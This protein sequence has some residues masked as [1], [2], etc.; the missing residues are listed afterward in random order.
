MRAV[1]AGGYSER[2]TRA[3]TR[4]WRRLFERAGKR[5]LTIFR[6][7]NPAPPGLAERENLVK[8][9]GNINLDRPRIAS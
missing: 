5:G 4:L 6:P 7:R 2:K 1:P 9:L 3:W 8:H